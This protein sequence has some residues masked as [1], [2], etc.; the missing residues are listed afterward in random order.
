MKKYL[1]VLGVPFVIGLLLLISIV[2][3]AFAAKSNRVH[4][5]LKPQ[6]GG[7]LMAQAI[8]N[9]TVTLPRSSSSGNGMTPNLLCSPAPC[10]MQNH[11]ASEGGNIQNETP[12]TVSP[13]NSQNLLS[14]ANDYNCSNSLQGFYSSSNGGSSFNAV[15]MNTL[16]GAFGEGDPGVAYDRLGNS[17][18]SG[19][20]GGTADGSDIVF[21]KSSDNGATWSAPAVAV[22]PLFAGG[23]TDKDWLWSDTS[24]HSSFVNSLYVSVTQFDTNNNTNITVTSSH[25][26]GATWNTTAVDTEQFYPSIDQFSDI[27]TGRDG[28]VYATWMRCTA[29]GPT[30]DCGGTVATMYMSKSSDGGSTFSTPVAIASVNLSPD[31]CG[32]FYGCLPNTFERVSDIPVIG[33]DNSTGAHAGNLYTVLYN[34]TGTFMQVEVTTSTDGGATWGTPVL[35]APASDTHDQFFPWLSVSSTG[36][37]GVTW[38][39]RRNDPSNVNYQAFSGISTDGGARIRDTLLTHVMSNPFNDGFGGGFMGD[40]TGNTWAGE[41]LYATWAD[42]RNGSFC[43]DEIGGRILA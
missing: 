41:K 24:T 34:W 21:E 2:P 31:S 8:H 18:I 27:T 28:T 29:N 25:D 15:C 38:L 32:A 13:V 20:D 4:L 26:G 16:S 1:R 9:G 11:Q 17:Y 7:Y 36:V 42:T 37:V 12:V 43:V 23:L 14:G 10:V 6:S 40:Y 33:S 22:R 5:P 19:I 3:G 39:D 35:A 30:G